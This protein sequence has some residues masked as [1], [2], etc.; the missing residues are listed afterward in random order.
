MS[1]DQIPGWDTRSRNP[2]SSKT[3]WIAGILIGLVAGGTGG[4]FAGVASTKAGKAL[5]EDLLT[6]EEPAAVTRPI[7]IARPGFKL[8]H[9]SNWKVDTK[10][11]DYD[12]DHNFTIESPGSS[13]VIFYV[14]DVEIDPEEQIRAQIEAQ[15]KKVVPGARQTPFTR[16]GRY[17]GKGVEL[18]GRMLGIAPGVTRIFAHGDERGGFLA[19]EMT[20]DDDAAAVRPGFALI[21]SSFALTR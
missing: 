13:M 21:E 4:F 14:F 3:P 15:T 16:W 12:P 7:A 1:D 11:E 2:R 17:E 19:V 8:Q 20:Y 10:D 6:D 5:F 9:P 18:R